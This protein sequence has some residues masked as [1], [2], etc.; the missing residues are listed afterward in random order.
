M[1]NGANPT[2]PTGDTVL[3]S[4]IAAALLLLLVWAVIRLA[5]SS[6]VTA[7]ER[8]GLL[9]FCLIFPVLGPICTLVILARRESVRRS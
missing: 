8:L 1:N 5:R 3:V 9:L 7:G 2:I 4:G 6:A